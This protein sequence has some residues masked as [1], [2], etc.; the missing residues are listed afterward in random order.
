MPMYDFS[1]S[2]HHIIV[3]IIHAAMVILYERRISCPS[4]QDIAQH[5]AHSKACTCA[6]KALQRLAELEDARQHIIDTGGQPLLEAEASGLEAE[7]LV[8]AVR[9]PPD[10][11][12]QACACQSIIDAVRED[13]AYSLCASPRLHRTHTHTPA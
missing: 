6:V 11:T 7:A 1:D 13:P 8:E 3:L 10:P 4:V 5:G 2:I 12:A 9:N